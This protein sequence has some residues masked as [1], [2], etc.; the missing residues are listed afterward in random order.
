MPTSQGSS[1]PRDRTHISYV[2]FI[3]KWVLQHQRHL[4]S[5]CQHSIVENQYLTLNIRTSLKAQLVKHPPARQE[6]P[7]QFLGWEDSLE[8]RQAT[9]ASILG[10]P[11]WL[12]WQRNLPAM[13]EIRVKFF[14]CRLASLNYVAGV[15]V[16]LAIVLLIKSKN[17]RFTDLIF[18][19]ISF[20]LQFLESFVGVVILAFGIRV[21]HDHSGFKLC[22]RKRKS[23]FF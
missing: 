9:Y 2:F 7:V 8:K 16:H 20:L 10:L 17:D 12:S 23:E 1:Q 22:G 13:Q 4:E 5:Q 14:F 21:G 18:Q 15:I 6:T 3:G 11:L 19:K